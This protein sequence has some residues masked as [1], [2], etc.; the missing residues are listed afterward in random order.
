MSAVAEVYAIG[1][2]VKAA[3]PRPI[4]Q[5]DAWLDGRLVAAHARLR[6]KV[7]GLDARVA[8]A[9]DPLE[10]LLVKEVLVEMVLR[11]VRNPEGYSQENDGDY[12]YT[13]DRAVA[14]GR[15]HVTAEELEELGVTNEFTGTVTMVDHALPHVWRD[16]RSVRGPW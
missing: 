14:S 8:S 13:R 11:V 2:D 12:G 15:L 6:A 4:K 5:S 9:T 10:S 3:H 7:P 16:E 1:E